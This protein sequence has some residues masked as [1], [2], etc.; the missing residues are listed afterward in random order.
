MNTL[1]CRE[2]KQF[3]ALRI[4]GSDERWKGAHDRNAVGARVRVARMLDRRPSG[5]ATDVSGVRNGLSAKP[6]VLR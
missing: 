5:R 3:S 6:Y 1:L 4:L 2:R